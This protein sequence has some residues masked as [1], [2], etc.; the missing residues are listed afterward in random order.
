[1][2]YIYIAHSVR[3]NGEKLRSGSAEVFLEA[4]RTAPSVVQY[5]EDDFHENYA[6]QS[7]MLR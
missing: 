5:A 2:S 4:C 6:A 3:V 7:L 1:M